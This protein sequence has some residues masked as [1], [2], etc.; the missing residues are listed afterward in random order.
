MI[1]TLRKIKRMITKRRIAIFD[2]DFTLAETNECILFKPENSDVYHR[3][4]PTEFNNI[5]HVILDRLD[6][7]AFVE[8]ED[9]NL[10]R[11]KPIV[12]TIN[13]M[14]KLYSE[15]Y[16]IVILS[17]RSMVVKSKIDAFMK[18]YTNVV[19]YEYIGLSSGDI[20]DKRDYIEKNCADDS[21]LIEDNIHCLADVSMLLPYR[22]NYGFVT[23][24]NNDQYVVKLYHWGQNEF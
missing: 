13:L 7:N 23:K 17:A 21:W 3:I 19:D 16:E 4:K 20:D 6:S 2:F 12:A 22:I 24:Q 14:H 11:C 18:M 10:N 15:G 8:F 9:I 5:R 1:S